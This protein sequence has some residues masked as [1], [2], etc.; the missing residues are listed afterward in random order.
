MLSQLIRF[1][2]TGFI[3]TLIDF[4]LFNLMVILS[5]AH[6]TFAITLINTLAVSL[7]VINSFF[8]NRSWTFPEHDRNN[9]Q[10]Q[11]FIAASVMGIII[12]SA[13]VS[14]LSNWS[15]LSGF[16]PLLVLNAAKTAGAL[17]SAGWNFLAYRNWVFKADKKT[18][19]FPTDALSPDLVSI[20]IPAY[21]E[22]QRLPGR[23]RQLAACLP[24][25]GSFEILVVD[26]GSSD[27][28]PQII[29]QFNHEFSFIRLIKHAYNQGKGAAVRSGMLAARGSYLLFTDADDTYT[30]EHIM[31]VTEKLRTGLPV[32][33]ACRS[34]QAG[35]RLTGEPR[36]RKWQGKCFNLLV[37]ALLLPGV[38]DSQ[39]GLKGFSRST[40]AALFPRQRING[41][42][43]DVELL[44]LLEALK[45]PLTVL[46]VSGADCP[47]STVRRILTPL[48]MALDV[49]KIKLALLLNLYQL[50]RQ[51]A[52]GLGWAYAA[53]LF[54]AALL[55]RIPWLWEVPR[56]VDELKEVQLAYQI[57]RGQALPLHNMAHD[58]GAIHNYILAGIFKMLGAGIYWPRLYVAVTSALTVVLIYFIGKKLFGHWT[59]L[60]AALLLLSNG[61][62]ILVTHMAWSN[63]TTPFFFCLAMLALIQAEEKKNSLWLIISAILWAITLQT[64]S[65][66]LIYVL[67][68]LAYVLRPSFRKKTALKSRTYLLAG[69]G[70]LLAY[71]NM[72][73][74]NLISK[75][76]SFSW[77]KYKGY[78]IE[79]NPGFFSYLQNL[80]EMV[81]ELLRAVSSTYPYKESFLAYL[82][83]PGFAIALLLLLMGTW[84]AVKE[85]KTLPLYIMISAFLL[86]PWINH[87]YVFY[88]AT[89]YIMPV[90]LCALLLISLAVVK[91]FAWLRQRLG[92]T[93]AL[94]IPA[95]S[96]LAAVM[97]LQLIPFYSYCSQKSDTNLSNRLALQVF[98]KTMALSDRR[99]TLVILDESIGLENDPLP[100]LL[101]IA[102]QPYLVSHAD[103]A[104]FANVQEYNHN[105]KSAARGSRR[106][107]GIVS[108]SS[109]QEMRTS[110]P[111]REIETYSCKLEMPPSARGERK[112]Y[113]LDLGAQSDTKNVP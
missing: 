77:L 82:A 47:G 11:R 91:N 98:Q 7:A 101:T 110:L 26:D 9:R 67:A 86:M 92:R 14:L 61:M 89:R 63:C 93:R 28:T 60:I 111:A 71:S 50:P 53:L 58:I 85:K 106:I 17:L 105:Q 15:L 73:Y 30:P 8:I 23:M 40:A 88:L 108:A 10:F 69:I 59:G 94:V 35:R 70:F 25:Q 33:I 16:A 68:V 44:A 99:S 19:D 78:A 81:I 46:E 109:F 49:I 84:W 57:Y 42:A 3:N 21:N 4:G 112:I 54:A 55:A 22:E 34:S 1:A 79:K 66:V 24:A 104:A 48:Q 52:P 29:E 38:K 27:H 39:C 74:Y 96:V 13:T 32:V 41:F 95:A 37:Q 65:S 80:Q 12:N 2:I 31:L 64:H 76:G 43:F 45:H 97:L 62:H 100:Y 20:I 83:Y 18:A 102:Q 72:I 5:G 87:R 51:K 6:S 107:V 56:Y 103:S 75:G 90:L 36:W 113:V